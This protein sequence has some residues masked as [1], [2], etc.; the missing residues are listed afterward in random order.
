MSE[1]TPDEA[2]FQRYHRAI[3]DALVGLFPPG[4]ATLTHDIR[5]MSHV[6]AYY[7]HRYVWYSGVSPRRIEDAFEESFL[8]YRRYIDRHG[9]PS[10]ALR[11]P[12]REEP[13]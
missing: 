10:A 1:R 13:K 8:F 5:I 9:E 12:E 6:F 7:F 3:H 2:T 4:G 11:P